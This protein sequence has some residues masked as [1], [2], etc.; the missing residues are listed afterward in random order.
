VASYWLEVGR[1]PHYQCKSHRTISIRGKTRR[2]LLYYDIS[3][4]VHVLWINLYI[5]S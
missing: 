2:I 5:F 4:T 3:N 1:L